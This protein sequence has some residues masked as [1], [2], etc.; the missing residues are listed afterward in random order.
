MSNE[1]DLGWVLYILIVK[2]LGRRVGISKG[3]W[4]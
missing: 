1:E 4:E 2:K 3:D